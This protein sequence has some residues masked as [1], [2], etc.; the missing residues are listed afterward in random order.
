ML[1]L[2][3]LIAVISNSSTVQ[4]KATVM[5]STLV[6]TTV[7]RYAMRQSQDDFMVRKYSKQIYDMERSLCVAS[8]LSPRSDS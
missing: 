1:S 5:S 2:V 6:G 3:F 7:T 8:L 4:F